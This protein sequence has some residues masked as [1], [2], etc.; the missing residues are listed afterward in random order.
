MNTYYPYRIVTVNPFTQQFKDQIN[1]FFD[2]YNGL[3]L[4]N[5]VKTYKKISKTITISDLILSNNKIN[6]NNYINKLILLT[7]SI[8][9]AFIYAYDV[10][11]SNEYKIYKKQIVFN[12]CG[13]DILN[14]NMC[15]SIIPF[16]NANKIKKYEKYVL[17]YLDDIISFIFTSKYKNKP[18]C[19]IVYNNS[20]T[21]LFYDIANIEKN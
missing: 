18:S 16:T 7:L 4:I 5:V 17:Q 3:D 13:K 8:K 6:I 15:F 9:D 10:N 20:D 12:I 2:M 1:V 11:V 19:C 21:A 14:T